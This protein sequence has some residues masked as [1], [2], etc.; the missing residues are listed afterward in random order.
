MSINKSLQLILVIVLLCCAP[1][2]GQIRDRAERKKIISRY[3]SH[4]THLKLLERD[5]V[6]KE[7]KIDKEV[8][9]KIRDLVK[10]LPERI[11]RETKNLDDRLRKDRENMTREE[12]RRLSAESMK[13]RADVKDATWDEIEEMLNTGQMKRLDQLA[14]QYQGHFWFSVKENQNKIGMTRK[15]ATDFLDR[16]Q[17]LQ[18][19]YSKEARKLLDVRDMDGMRE[20]ATKLAGDTM[21]LINEIMTEEQKRKY[22]DLSGKK[23][24]WSN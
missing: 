6:N 2:Q 21:K 7:L 4:R 3:L 13:I 19:A 15:Q 23:F 20:L 17:V 11:K 16:K 5:D 18:T 24:D 10:T 22:K 14:I 9:E 1:V 12:K 8:R